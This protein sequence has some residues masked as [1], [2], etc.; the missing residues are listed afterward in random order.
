MTEY[1]KQVDHLSELSKLPGMREHVLTRL[2]EL[3]DE[4]GF[5]GITQDVFARVRAEKAVSA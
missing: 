1:Q 3:E 4:P 5:A 2:R